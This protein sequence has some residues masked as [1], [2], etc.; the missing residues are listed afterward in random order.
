MADW[1]Q[2]EDF[3][4]V[5]EAERAGARPDACQV[6]EA[7]LPD[8]VDGTLSEAEQRAFDR[9]LA[10]CVVCSRELEEAQRGAA[11]LGLLK[12]QA[13]EPDAAL[14]ER[15]LAQTTGAA[16]ANT[17]AAAAAALPAN[18]H[19]AAQRANE[20]AAER[21][22]QQAAEKAFAPSAWAGAAGSYAGAGS[23]ARPGW[24][25]AARQSVRSVFSLEWMRPML[26][27]R[28]A[29]TAAMAFFSIALT[30]NLTGVRLN[31]LSASSLRPSAV[32]RVV[33]DRSAAAVRSFQNLRVVYQ[34]EAQVNDLRSNW[35]ADEN[36]RR[37]AP[38]PQR[39]D[40]QPKQ[41]SQDTP[42]GSSQLDFAPVTPQRPGMTRKGA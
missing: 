8:A 28:M 10:G 2:F 29:M 24:A 12:Q 22:T 14:L 27:P 33:A 41:H 32:R 38:A 15:I 4:D 20:R 30:L 5:R 39:E 31:E 25:V 34:A 23:K 42:Q 35:E 19:L 13:P 37:P 16:A 26:Q 3:E 7:M 11:W 21:T 17:Q 1:G 40:S 36:E 18:V 6:C 9:H